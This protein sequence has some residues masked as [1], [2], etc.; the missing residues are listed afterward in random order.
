MDEHDWQVERFE[1]E[2]PHLQAMAYRI[3]GS[4]PE[5]E[6]AVQES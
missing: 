1:E 4:L 5:A 3:P 2:R 6:D